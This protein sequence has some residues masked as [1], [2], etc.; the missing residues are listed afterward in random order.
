M[1]NRSITVKVLG[2]AQ[3]AGVP[4]ANCY[5]QRC[6]AAREDSA[7]RRFA[8]AL[9]LILPGNQGWYLLEATPD[10]PE[11]LTIL[12]SA[13]PELNLMRGIFLTHAHI[14]HYAGLM[15]LGKEAIASSGIPVW[16]GSG[17]QALLRHSAPW[18]QLVDTENIVLQSLQPGRSVSL[19]AGVCVTPWLVPHRNEFAETFAFLI[20]GPERRLL[21]LPDL[22]RWEQWE[23][24]LP[25]IARHV[26][27]LFLDGTFFSADEL[28]AQGRD[29]AQIPHPLVKD[30]MDLL[31]PVADAGH[32]GIY[33]F[34]L[35]HT[36]PLLDP[37]SRET[38]QLR[39]RGFHVATEGMEL[40]I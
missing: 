28:A 38:R 9:A 22:D 3:D 8:T 32:A 29:Y 1:K 39:Q 13:R 23:R 11:H 2:T 21:F 36:N 14:G 25:D 26:D 30:T 15:Y 37:A 18:S 17:L 31:Q 40:Q 35:N 7:R 12:H 20:C 34:H 5:C 24:S 27:Y 4:Q 6:Q 10:L 19:P 33:F 16:A